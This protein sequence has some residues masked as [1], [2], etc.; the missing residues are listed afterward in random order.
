ML[1]QVQGQAMGIGILQVTQFKITEC[2]AQAHTPAGLHGALG[3]R[4]RSALQRLPPGAFPGTGRTQQLSRHG[5]RQRRKQAAQLLDFLVVRTV[6]PQQRRLLGVGI[7]G[8]KETMP[9]RTQTVGQGIA[10]PTQERGLIRLLTCQVAALAGMQARYHPFHQALALQ[11]GLGDFQRLDILC[12]VAMGLQRLAEMLDALVQLDCLAFWP[13]R[14]QGQ[15][16]R[17]MRI[18]A[19]QQF[20]STDACDEFTDLLVHGQPSPGLE[21]HAGHGQVIAINRAQLG[22]GHPT[23]VG[24]SGRFDVAVGLGE[25]PQAPHQGRPPPTLGLLQHMVPGTLPVVFQ[26]RAKQVSRPGVHDAPFAEGF[27]FF[28][29]V[30]FVV[31]GDPGLEIDQIEPA[32]IGHPLGFPT[33]ILRI[34]Q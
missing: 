29:L 8:L 10:Q 34:R 5:A 14:Q 32:A 11:V 18:V 16:P 17:H 3:K 26:Y 22:I 4:Q 21:Q 6:P 2:L 13:A 1:Q 33:R 15:Q 12:L 30:D 7:E 19:W 31:D 23:E 27:I 25:M 28:D 20:A 24:C 9:G